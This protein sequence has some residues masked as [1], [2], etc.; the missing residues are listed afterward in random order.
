MLE[1]GIIQT[2]FSPWNAPLL[3][4][5]KK[6]D[7]EGNARYRVVLD[8]RKLNELTVG[9]SYPLPN[10]SPKA[11][12]FTTLDLASGYH[13]IP[14]DGRDKEKTAFST[15]QGHFEFNR[16]PFGLRN[17]PATFQ[18]LMN[19]ILMG[20]QGI[21]CFVYLDDLVI[22]G[23][24]LKEH[25][26][27]LRKV[28]EKLREYNLKLQPEK[29]S[30]LCKEVGFLG[31]II[32]PERIKPDP[33]KIKAV[34]KYPVPTKLKEVQSFLGLAGYYR[35]F[36]PQYSKIARPLSK[37]TSDKTEFVWTTKQQYAFET[38]KNCLITAPVLAYP[39]FSKEF[40]ITTDAS[41]VAIG[42]ILSQGVIGED[43]PIAYASRVLNKAE[44]I[45]NTTEKE[46]LAIVWATKQFRPYVYGTHF[47]VV[48]DHKA[49]VWL[50]RVQDPGSRLIR[51]RIQLAEHD[52]EIIHKAGKANTNADALS[53]NINIIQNE[54]ESSAEITKPNLGIIEVE[55]EKGRQQI[56]YE[57]H[58]VPLGGH[59]GIQRTAQR[60]KQKHKWKNTV[61]MVP[62]EQNM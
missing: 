37:L 5:P 11:Q 9:D 54:Q 33:E 24:S 59:Q 36:I 28:M 7:V 16:M 30:F 41:D 23:N 20:L 10:T 35:R 6:K 38:L 60:I 50:F 55:A 47:K 4:V 52:Y 48:T 8:F 44:K 45:Y 1:D 18:R 57:Y 31:H 14:M 17:A 29:C 56:L 2:S 51:W 40:I 34:E 19:T 58:L 15:P 21:D 49:L 39:D 3:V 25:N 46:L 53:R 42:A 22:F 27:R 13:Q 26:I 43:R 32:T 61:Y 12:Y 62:K